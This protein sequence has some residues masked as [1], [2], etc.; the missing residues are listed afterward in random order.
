MRDQPRAPPA[1]RSWPG[2]AS[3]HSQMHNPER[4]GKEDKHQTQTGYHGDHQ[5]PL[6]GGAL[7]F[8]MPET[9]NDPRGAGDGQDH[10]NLQHTEWLGSTPRGHAPP[11]M[12]GETR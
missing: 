8:Q 5:H 1:T 9:S 3:S 6:H 4:V 7:I 2:E 12:P 11:P 10:P